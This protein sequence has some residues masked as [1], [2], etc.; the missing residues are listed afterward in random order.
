[1]HARA[2]A[3]WGTLR[4]GMK[5]ATGW[6]GEGNEGGELALRSEGILACPVC[7]GRF[8][9]WGSEQLQL[10]QAPCLHVISDRTSVD[11]QAS[12]GG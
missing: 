3:V 12:T 2:R 9:A 11:G 10:R 5:R 6:V 7:A 1:V 8:C 4:L